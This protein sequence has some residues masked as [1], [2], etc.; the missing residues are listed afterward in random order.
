MNIYNIFTFL[1]AFISTVLAVSLRDDGNS[2][3]LDNDYSTVVIAKS[4]G[5]ITSLKLKGR[6]EEF[7]NRSYIDANGGKV[8][9]S[10]T[11][12]KVIKNTSSHVEVAF[13]DNYRSGSKLG[14]DWEV[15]YTMLSDSR[16]VYFSLANTHKSSYPDTSYSEIRLVLRLKA[17]IFDYLQV[18]D[19]VKRV[20]PSAADQNKCVEM[21]PKEACK[22]PNGEVIHKYD[23]S[24]DMLKHN[25]H[26]FS[27]RSTGLGCW[28]VSPSMEWK[29]GGAY[30]RD[31]SCHQGGSDSLQI[32]YM[33]GSHYGGGDAT[34]KKGEEFQKVYGPFLIYLNRANSVEAAWSD[35]KNAARNE[36]KKWPYSF[37]SQ[38]GYVKE[39]GK[40]SGTLAIN[41]PLTGKRLP[42]E[43]AVVVLVQQPSS[44]EPIPNQ[45][46]RH[47]S[48]WTHSLSG[49]TP[50]FVIYAVVPGTYQL[51]AWSKNVVGEFILDKLV[52]VKAN[53]V[54]NL[55]KFT[56]NENRIAPIA[57][58][59][60]V[61]DR[62]AMEYKHG[63][64]FNQ[65]GL[66]HKFKDEFP[67]GVNYYVGKS[68]YAK[69]WN[70]CQVS[71][72]GSDGKYTGVPWNIYFNLDKIP[73]GTSA[74]RISIA[75][76]SFAALSVGLNDGKVSA[77][78]KDLVDDACIRRDGIRG[79]YRE[80]EF[81]YEPSAFK[82]GE[83]KFTLYFRKT[84]G[85]QTYYQ[86]DGIMY[87]HI[88]F[89]APFDGATSTTQPQPQQDPEPQQEPEQP[90]PSSNAGS[91]S[92]LFWQ[93]G[94]ANWKGAT[95]CCEG[96]CQKY[97]DL[98]SQCVP[99][100]STSQPTQTQ[101]A[102]ATQTQ[103]AQPTQ[104]QADPVKPGTIFI[105]GDST[106]DENGAN[107]RKTN[108]WGKYIKDYVSCNVSNQAHSGESARTFWRD[109]RWNS[110]IAGVK[111]NDYVF[112]QFGH[113]DVGGPNNASEKGSAGGEGDE[114]VTVTRKNGQ[115]EVVHTFPWYI[116]EMCKQVIAKGAK[117]VVLSYTPNFSFTNGKVGEGSRFQGFMKLV[118]TRLDIPYIDLYSLIARKWEELGEAYIKNNNW[119]PTDYKHTS[120]EAADFNAQMVVTGIKC[121]N[122]PDLVAVLNNKGKGVNN[123]C[124]Y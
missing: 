13:Y 6:N 105:A 51:R 29:N 73:S 41:D 1:F 9:F 11:S 58:E 37:V 89:E 53:E 2:Y 97:N 33:N 48:H 21:G 22:L 52:T 79:I 115:Q 96:K 4:S 57:W 76:S 50:N 92:K 85:Y 87:D 64:H 42:L 78:V 116:S 8:Y 110:L 95:T 70:Y 101:A 93:C 18:E 12:S 94:G 45:Q 102:Q 99:N 91:C 3:I 54:T 44:T 72:P 66:Y 60:G 103:A 84:G 86:F 27:S 17:N 30:N 88:R 82:V 7:L 113:N 32:M 10:P 61:P 55:G 107:N 74:L 23:Y 46:W 43:D 121:V 26:G 59:I 119:F 122:I 71:I 68:N 83:N 20:M 77:E 109:G 16:G 25:V 123:Q 49:N 111:K 31:L 19:D 81:K 63:D 28:F 118:G 62:T 24:V 36:G 47:T 114:T 112:I 100:G 80:L 98:F 75:A 117:P 35:A 14:L 56:F 69:D 39:R 104:K 106:A 120:P 90:E 67:N 108:G 15:R 5:Y 65:W 124:K 40:V 38:P 34:I